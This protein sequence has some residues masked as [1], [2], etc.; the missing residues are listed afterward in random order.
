MTPDRRETLIRR[1]AGALYRT[2]AIRLASWLAG[3]A[4]RRPAFPILTYHR[5]N[6]DADD[7]L[8]AISTKVFERHMVYV[9]SAYR[10]MPLDEMVQRARKGS[11][12]RNSL[13]L[14]FDDG[15]R[16]NLT[17]AA[18]ILHRHGLPATVF[19]AT[20][21][22]GTGVMSWFDRLAVALKLTRMRTVRTPWGETLVLRDRTARLAALER[23]QNH[24]KTLGD[25]DL[26]RALDHLLET[27]DV[28]DAAAPKNLMLDWAD[29]RA[30]RGLGFDVGGHTV[31]HVILSR[32]SDERAWAEIRGSSSAIEAGLGSRP[33]AFAYPNGRAQD[34]TAS[35]I[36]L[37]RKAGF[38]WAVTTRFGLNTVQTPAYELRRG[39][40]WEPDV[41]TFALKLAVYRATHN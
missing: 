35:T 3:Y 27:L 25:D 17:H 21:L 37:V 10:V 23:A 13:A 26:Q 14:T 38:A 24:L 1:A 16:D 5:V 36:D 22:I 32:V 31:S 34:Y 28:P 7:F 39:G 8:P 6:D 2:R 19:L 29:A 40:P 30:L 15:Y 4:G 33:T 18:P 9:A 20:G 12:P 41:A 11:L